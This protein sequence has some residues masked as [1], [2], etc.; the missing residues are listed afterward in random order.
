[1]ID[2][3][4]RLPPALRWLVRAMFFA[5][6]FGALCYAIPWGG[7]GDLVE[8]ARRGAI[9]G[10]LYATLLFWRDWREFSRTPPDR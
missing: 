10:A 8:A 4:R 7:A 9:F 1:M 5:A 3:S 6:S 2:W